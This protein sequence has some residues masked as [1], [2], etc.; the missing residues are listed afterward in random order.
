MKLRMKNKDMAER[1]TSRHCGKIFVKRTLERERY[2]LTNFLTEVY[3]S[4]DEIEKLMLDEPARGMTEMASNR[5]QM[6]RK[7]LIRILHRERKN[8]LSILTGIQWS[9]DHLKNC[10]GES[11]TITPLSEIVILNK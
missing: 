2:I 3:I 11:G 8:I 7:Y 10:L 4:L 1:E 5:I 9:L 6:E